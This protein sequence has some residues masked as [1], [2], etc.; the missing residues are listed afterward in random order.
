M[1]ACYSAPFKTSPPEWKKE[2]GGQRTRPKF[3]PPARG[4]AAETGPKSGPHQLCLLAEQVLTIE[5]K[6]SLGGELS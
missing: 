1:K 5:T 4:L 2:A 3:P 6:A